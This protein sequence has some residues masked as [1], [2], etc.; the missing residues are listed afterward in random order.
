M[1]PE[2]ASD[3]LSLINVSF[4]FGSALCPFRSS[5]DR[6]DRV[7][8]ADWADRDRDQAFKKV[9][10]NETITEFLNYWITEPNPLFKP[11]VRMSLGTSPADPWKWK[12]SNG[13]GKSEM[14][15]IWCISITM[16]NH[17]KN[18]MKQLKRPL[19]SHW[20]PVEMVHIGPK[21]CKRKLFFSVAKFFKRYPAYAIW[22]L[23]SCRFWKSDG[24]L[25]YHFL[26]RSYCWSKSGQIWRFFWKVAASKKIDTRSKIFLK[27][28]PLERSFKTSLWRICLWLS[29]LKNFGIGV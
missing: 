1:D 27:T 2:L 26:N 24:S 14:S 6:A 9:L 23:T 19:I 12:W 28:I 13:V 15:I 18:S 17:A 25:C 20:F 8:R 7:N 16:W 10:K 22:K 21:L 11:G 5:A 29:S 3:H 4:P